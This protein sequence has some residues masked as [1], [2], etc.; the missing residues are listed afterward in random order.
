MKLLYEELGEGDFLIY[1]Q[2]L[3]STFPV[4][5]QI[6]IRVGVWKIRIHVRKS[7]GGVDWVCGAKNNSN[8]QLSSS[9]E[10][11]W[12]SSGN[13]LKSM[14]QAAVTVTLGWTHWQISIEW[15][16]FNYMEIQWYWHLKPDY[17]IS[18]HRHNLYSLLRYDPRTFRKQSAK[19]MN[20]LLFPKFTRSRTAHYHHLLNRHKDCLIFLSSVLYSCV[21]H[22]SDSGNNPEPATSIMTVSP[23]LEHSLKFDFELSPIVA[24]VQV[25]WPNF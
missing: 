10:Q 23:E 14:L 6:L 16:L 17:L 24:C 2:R 4:E 22:L 1:A 21:H 5:H 3:I 8:L 19:K 20:A 11:V 12:E 9:K 7:P 25:A 18:W 15:F 13:R